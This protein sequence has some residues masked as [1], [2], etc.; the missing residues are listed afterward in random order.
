MYPNGFSTDVFGEND[1]KV[2][3]VGAG[4]DGF[5]QEFIFEASGTQLLRVYL[6]QGSSGGCYSVVF[7]ANGN[8]VLYIKKDQPKKEEMNHGATHDM[9]ISSGTYKTYRIKLTL[10]SS[11]QLKITVGCN[12]M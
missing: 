2:F 12:L 1:A 4:A 6:C 3:Q 11:N 9:A 8:T 5:S 10:E 7:G